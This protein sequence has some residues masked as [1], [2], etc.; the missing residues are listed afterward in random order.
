MAKPS[1]GCWVRKPALSSRRFGWTPPWTM[2]KR[3]WP[4]S[5]WFLAA[6]LRRAQRWVRS[7]ASRVP[8]SS[9]R[10]SM[11][12]SSTIMMSEPMAVCTS[13]ERSGVSISI[14]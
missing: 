2:A 10:E 4:V 13:M 8:A 14:C 1:K 6:R 3:A 9:V 12:T 7:M 5:T 11:H